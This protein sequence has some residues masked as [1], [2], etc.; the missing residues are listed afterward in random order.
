MFQR[1]DLTWQSGE[2]KRI[3]QP[4]KLAVTLLNGAPKQGQCGIKLQYA[5]HR[6]QKFCTQ[7]A[8]EPIAS[9]KAQRLI[10]RDGRMVIADHLQ[11]YRLD[12]LLLQKHQQ[13]LH[14]FPAQAFAAP[15][16]A[17]GKGRQASGTPPARDD[18]DRRRFISGQPDAGIDQ[19]HPL[20]AKTLNKSLYRL[21]NRHQVGFKT[22]VENIR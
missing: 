3:Q 8:A 18:R 20:G 19:A 2:G 6:G 13:L 5:R 16:R 10:Q 22:G 7:V 4:G 1:H 21:G 14:Q 11:E 17:Q 12:P 9:R 15:G